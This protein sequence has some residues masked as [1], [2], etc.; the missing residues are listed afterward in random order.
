MG[1]EKCKR[2]KITAVTAIKF[3]YEFFFESASGGISLVAFTLITF[4]KCLMSYKSKPVQ[5]LD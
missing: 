4:H 1:C 3:L 5:N 2:K